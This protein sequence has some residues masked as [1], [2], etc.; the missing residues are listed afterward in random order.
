MV[1]AS[2]LWKGLLAVCSPCFHPFGFLIKL[3]FRVNIKIRDMKKLFLLATIMIAAVTSISAQRNC[4]TSEYY[5]NVVKNFPG[6]S[7]RYG[8]LGIPDN[9]IA[10]YEA[11][12]KDIIIPVAVHIVWN[13]EE[14]RVKRSMVEQQINILNADFAAGNSDIQNVPSAFAT[15]KAGNSGIIFRLDTITYT[16]TTKEIF[17]VYISDKDSTIKKNEPIKFSDFGG[18]DGFPNTR[19]L[20]IW[21]GNIRNGRAPYRLLCGYATPPGGINIFDGVVINYSCLGT[22]GLQP[23]FD[24]GRTATHEVGHWLNLR[25]LWGNNDGG[26]CDNTDDGVADTPPQISYNADCPTFPQKRDCTKDT[27]NGEMFMNFL[28]YVNDPCMVMFSAGQK[29]RMRNCFV[30]YPDRAALLKS[31]VKISDIGFESKTILNPDITSFLQGSN[32]SILQWLESNAG[33][34]YNI[35][36]K[37]LNTG[38]TDK[39]KL[40]G[41]NKISISSLKPGGLYEV[42]VQVIVNKDKVIEGAP[43]LFIADAQTIKTDKKKPELQVLQ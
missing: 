39:L 7:G 1:F 20:N 41:E 36:I 10:D 27:E 4:L 40:I 38:K 33:E 43:Y 17:D 28:D 11:G 5:N 26:I 30:Q 6:L 13:K 12:L 37:D 29:K 32:S 3:Y 24:K 19:Y 34:K 25:H 35:L 16:E 18:K 42:I 14:Q 31:S 2:L 9:A 21:V 22:P 8:V 15:L 23:K